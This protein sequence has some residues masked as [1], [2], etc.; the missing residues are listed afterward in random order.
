MLR[1]ERAGCAMTGTFNINDR[2]GFQV[3]VPH[4]S[5]RLNPLTVVLPLHLE[6]VF[7]LD[8]CTERMPLPSVRNATSRESRNKK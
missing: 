5:C 4:P 6:N 3:I 2:V 8:P 1:K 7:D